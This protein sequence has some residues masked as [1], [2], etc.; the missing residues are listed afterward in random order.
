MS[1]DRQDSVR[2]RAYQLWEEEG[3]PEGQH[4][5]HWRDAEDELA[6]KTSVE[7]NNE[8]AGQVTESDDGSKAPKSPIPSPPIASPD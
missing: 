4:E 7:D 8:A 1:D 2:E 3:H 6:D 5:R